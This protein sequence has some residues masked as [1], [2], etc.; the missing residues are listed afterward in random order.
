MLTTKKRVVVT[1]GLVLSL[2]T[3]GSKPS[4]AATL[5]A[6]NAAFFV[7]NFSYNS[8]DIANYTNADA[9]TYV[10]STGGKVM[11]TAVPTAF[12]NSTSAFNNS[13]SSATGESGNYFGTAKSLAEIG[14]YNFK[15]AKD[16]TFSFDFDGV[17]NLLT[18]IDSS[19]HETANANGNIKFEVVNQANGEVL[20]YLYLFGNISTVDNNDFLNGYSS[21]SLTFDPNSTIFDRNFGGMQEYASAI[22]R[23]TYSRTFTEDTVLSIRESKFNQV[24]VQV[25]EPLSCGGM[26]VAGLM[27]LWIKRKQKLEH[28]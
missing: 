11:A 24:T 27:G 23:G 14:L 5:A 20:D 6:S 19:P 17:L 13:D 4:Q 16:T 18:S 26:L 28:E 21:A 22:F 10:S 9:D 25:P 3:F 1:A 7:G 8:P 12:A 2:A 15:I